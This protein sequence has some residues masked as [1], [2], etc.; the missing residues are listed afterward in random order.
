MSPDEQREQK[1]RLR[2]ELEDAE[3][4]LAHLREA[5]HARSDLLTQFAEWLRD[6]P[7][8]KIYHASGSVH[9]GFAVEVLPEKYVRVQDI[10]ESLRLADDIRKARRRVLDLQVRLDKLP[11]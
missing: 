2:I 9:C 10:K 5:A 4:D 8:T 11:S 6:S 1:M 7:E 3:K